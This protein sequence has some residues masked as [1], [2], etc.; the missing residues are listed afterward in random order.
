MTTLRFDRVKNQWLPLTAPPDTIVREI[1]M[2]DSHRS[3]LSPILTTVDSHRS[4]LSPILTT[5][6][7]PTQNSL[8]G[9]T[10][11]VNYA[12]KLKPALDANKQFFKKIYVVTDPTDFDTIDA[13]KDYQQ[14]ELVLNADVHLRG[15]DFNKSGLLVAAQDKAHQQ[16]ANDWIVLFDADTLLPY[17]F[18][19]IINVNRIDGN[20]MYTI[21]R[22]IYLTS[23]DLKNKRERE[24]TNGYGFFQMYYDKTKF[25]AKWSHDAGQC[26]D[27]FRNS[28]SWS[29]QLSGG[30]CAHL[31]ENAK[32]WRGRITEQWT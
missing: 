24:Q 6:E 23:T 19:E 31:G 3:P 25:Y 17:N 32:D 28:F 1:K 29:A 21:P 27:D 30:F 20:Y 15:A 8:V 4:P 2:V 14:V 9:I 13:V 26:D 11:C 18:W 7:K 16:F 10:V 12:D 5:V 22:K